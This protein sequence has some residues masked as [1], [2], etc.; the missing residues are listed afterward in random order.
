M[1]SLVEEKKNKE[2][3]GELSIN[4]KE[5]SVNHH[6]KQQQH[7][8]VAFS[9]STWKHKFGEKPTIPTVTVI[10][11]SKNPCYQE[12]CFWM[13]L[14]CHSSYLAGE[15]TKILD[16][17]KFY[18]IRGGKM[19]FLFTVFSSGKLFASFSYQACELSAVDEMPVYLVFLK[20][21]DFWQ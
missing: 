5:M 18:G 6:W 9:T 16:I 10:C 21:E 15:E 17:R 1:Y 14:H 8:L 20:H 3:K 12:Y 2:E 7:R 11:P 19:L 13:I 4:L